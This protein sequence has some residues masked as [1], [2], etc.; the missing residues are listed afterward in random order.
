MQIAEI[1]LQNNKTGCLRDQ[2]EVCVCVSVCV[3]VVCVY[4]VLCVCVC[5][6]VMCV[7]VVCVSVSASVNVC[8][9]LILY[10]PMHTVHTYVCTHV[11]MCMRA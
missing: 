10:F 11:S 6:Y 4:V 9:E 1:L 8:C 5:V 2:D 7:Y 3:C